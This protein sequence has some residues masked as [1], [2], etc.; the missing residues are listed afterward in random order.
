ML[1]VG[2][3]GGIGAGKSTFAAL[4]A[5]RGAQV[6]DADGLGRDALRPGR[7]SWHSVVAQ[8]GEEILVPNTMEVDRKRLAD[9][10]FNDP[11]KLAALNAIVHPVIFAGIAD[12]LERLRSTD[13]IVVLDAAL[14]YETGLGEVV[15]ATIAVLAPEGTRSHRLQA[16][17]GMTFDESARR[18]R[19]QMDPADLEARADF[20]VR[21]DGSLEGL[22]EEADRVWAELQARPHK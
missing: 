13:A 14:L 11:G 15:D 6:V 4:L 22:A 10:V 5:E 16:A 18:M 2:L 8:F 12:A 3:T 9:I 7:P 19:A 17:R 21:N 1:V 20:L